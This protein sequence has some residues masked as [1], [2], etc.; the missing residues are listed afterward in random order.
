MKEK[1]KYLW[2]GIGIVALIF[3][4]SSMCDG[5]NNTTTNESPEQILKVAQTEIKGEL[6]GCYEVVDK[7]YRVKF[8]QESYE[9]DVIN[10]E[11]KRTTKALP[12]DRKNVVIFAKGDESMAENCAGFGIEVLDSYG[13]VVAKILANAT[14]YSW[15]EMTA[16]LQLLEE[17]TTTIG[18]HI[19]DLPKEAVS[20][21]ITSLVMDNNER[22]TSTID[23]IEK[24]INKEYESLLE[25]SK[26]IVEDDEL[27][28]AVEMTKETMEL[29][30]KMLE[31][32]GN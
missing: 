28:E 14:P 6:K 4:L 10:V 26:D 30:G 5:G 13:D 22:R 15:D 24:Q 23:T 17:E 31:I 2:M 27:K 3:I 12:Y 25:E 20:F 18:F 11:L 7:N 29:A 9:S 21:R 32:F 1:K 8:A 16:A 19:K